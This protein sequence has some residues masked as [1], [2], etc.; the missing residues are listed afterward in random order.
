M[1]LRAIIM[2]ALLLLAPTLAGAQS[3]PTRSITLVVPF[4]AGGGRTTVQI[5]AMQNKRD[6][7]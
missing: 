2:A 3:W 1:I 5:T 4:A 6:N 7:A